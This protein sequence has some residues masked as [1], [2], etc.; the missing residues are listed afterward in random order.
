MMKTED[1]VRL[2]EEHPKAQQKL[3]WAISGVHGSDKNK[4]LTIERLAW[5]GWWN[6]RKIFFFGCLLEMRLEDLQG[7]REIDSAWMKFKNT[8]TEHYPDVVA[9]IDGWLDEYEQ[10]DPKII[11]DKRYRD[12]VA[13]LMYLANEY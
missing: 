3:L 5:N 13:K 6:A 4:K 11:M 10:E 2:F 7:M 9:K 8:I 1:L 12:H